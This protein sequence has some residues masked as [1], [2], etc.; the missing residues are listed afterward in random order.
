[1]GLGDEVTKICTT[2]FLGNGYELRFTEVVVHGFT[3]KVTHP[4]QSQSL[5]WGLTKYKKN[6]LLRYRDIRLNVLLSIYS[7][8]MMLLL[9]HFMFILQP[10]S[11]FSKWL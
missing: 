4:W 3:C 5:S 1:M 6:S 11:F 9:P 7:P 8:A 2:S 10:T